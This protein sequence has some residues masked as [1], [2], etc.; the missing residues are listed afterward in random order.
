MR[1]AF[2]ATWKPCKSTSMGDLGWK[3]GKSFPCYLQYDFE[4][5][6]LGLQLVGHGMEIG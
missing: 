4:A 6:F 1:R 3:K 2:D 5:G